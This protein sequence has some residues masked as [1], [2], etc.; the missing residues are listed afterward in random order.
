MPTQRYTSALPAPGKRQQ[1][2]ES[3]SFIWLS[4]PGTLEE[5]I[6]AAGFKPLPISFAHA[7]RAG[8]YENDH[9]DPFDRLLAAQAEL[10]DLVLMTNDR[11]L[12]AFPC[13]TLW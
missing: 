6:V 1:R 8:S 3:A 2:R 12:A 4:R 13:R 5:Q 9:R 10:E 7:T 11:A